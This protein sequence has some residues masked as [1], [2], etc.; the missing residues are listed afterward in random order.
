MLWE[1]K[2]DAVWARIIC[3]ELDTRGLDGRAT[4]KKAGIAESEV[5]REGGRIAIKK[6]DALF[7][8]AASV[9]GDDFFG[10]NLAARTDPRELGLLAYLGL[11][12]ETLMDAVRNL[13]RYVSV[14]T[15][16]F[17]IKFENRN[18]GFM[19]HAVMNGPEDFTSRQANEAGLAILLSAYR[20]F[21]GRTITPLEVHFR[22]GRKAGMNTFRKAFGCPVLFQ[23]E[24][25]G[26]LL[27]P[28][29]LSI[30]LATADDKLFRVLRGYCEDI[31]SRKR[32]NNPP[33]LNEA[34]ARIV[35][36][37]PKG[38]ASA[39]AVAAELGMSTRT[40]LRRLKESGTSFQ[41]LVDGLRADLAESYLSDPHLSTKEI[42]FLLGY[43][44]PS[45][46]SHGFRRLSGQTPGAYRLAC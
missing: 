15:D 21:S 5:S 9:T 36:L 38:Q 18:G 12:S 4:L 10:L 39:K 40:F 8:L 46:F 33:F 3:R 26:L 20:L 14:F 30:P 23:S 22:H 27:D 24:T 43:S 16:K 7:E 19:V 11:S 34:S 6:S 42:A 2:V 31:L 25:I 37:L 41:E 44:S 13:A 1:P 17:V 45:A 35:N 32:Q 28:E 29:D